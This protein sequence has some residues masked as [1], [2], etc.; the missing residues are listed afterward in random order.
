[1]LSKTDYRELLKVVLLQISFNQFSLQV[2]QLT[3]VQ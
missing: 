3:Y 2:S 1:M